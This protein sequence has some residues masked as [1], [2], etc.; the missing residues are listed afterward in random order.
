MIE[1]ES[2]GCS[3]L[4][5]KEKKKRARHNFIISRVMNWFRCRQCA[6]FNISKSSKFS[7]S[8]SRC[9]CCCCC[10]HWRCLQW[11]WRRWKIISTGFLAQLQQTH[12]NW[13][14]H[15]PRKLIIVA[16]ISAL[17]VMIA[18][19]KIKISTACVIASRVNVYS[20]WILSLCRCIFAPKLH[21]HANVPKNEKQR[22]G[23]ARNQRE[24]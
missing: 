1:N 10:R 19:P 11:W 15:L 5:A 8:M 16:I 18:T 13:M 3:I 14:E 20:C 12:W 21:K 7:R 4:N 23:T 2:N 17:D 22:I 6:I 24:N 9:C